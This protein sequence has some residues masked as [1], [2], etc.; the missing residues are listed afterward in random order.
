MKHE[1]KSFKEKHPTL[2]SISNDICEWMVDHKWQ[3]AAAEILMFIYIHTLLARR[4][5]NEILYILKE[6]E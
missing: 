2:C 3:I 1:K 5:I 4:G 6:K